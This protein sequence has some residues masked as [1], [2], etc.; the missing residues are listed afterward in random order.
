MSADKKITELP[1]S[2]LQDGSAFIVATDGASHKTTAA[3]I[4]AYSAHAQTAKP[5][6]EATDLLLIRDADGNDRLVTAAAAKTFF[7]AP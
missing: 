7:K 3:K 1:D 6:L 2:P 5:A 4:K